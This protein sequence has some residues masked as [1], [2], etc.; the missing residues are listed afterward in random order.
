MFM[1]LFFFCFLFSEEI[2][3]DDFNSYKDTNSFLKEWK[4]RSKDYKKTLKANDYYYFINDSNPKDKIL[5]SSLRQIPK[6]FTRIDI[7]KPNMVTDSS[8]IKSVSMYKD[9]WYHRLYIGDKYHEKNKEVLLTFKWMA[10]LLPI[11]ADNDDPKI[12]DNA[13]SVYIVLYHSWMNFKTLKYVWS[14]SNKIGPVK[15]YLNDKKKREIVIDNSN[16]KLDTWI[17]KKLNISQ[18][19]K[20]Y[21][22]KIYNDVEIIA[23]A[24]MADSDNVYKASYACVDDIN[25]EIID[26]SKKV[27]K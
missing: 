10:K 9:Y 6:D 4:S 7:K 14:S 27:S 25:I 5:C 16:S 21:W 12:S 15:R 3:I 17:N 23:V 20:K 26:A 13:I 24:V 2:L 11:G 19:I 18:D 1:F 8:Q 22:P